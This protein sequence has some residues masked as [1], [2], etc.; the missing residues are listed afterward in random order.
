MPTKMSREDPDQLL[1]DL[2]NP[3]PYFRITDSEE[4]FTNIHNT[5]KQ[6]RPLKT[7]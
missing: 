1:I 6:G 3:D 2:L 7:H 5:A 4:M